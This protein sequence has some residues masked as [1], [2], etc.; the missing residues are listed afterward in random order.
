[1]EKK[2][3][4]V[5]NIKNATGNGN[6]HRPPNNTQR[7]ELAKL[8]ETMYV[9]KTDEAKDRNGDI[10]ERVKREISEKL[11]AAEL[12]R[13]IKMFEERICDFEKQK[14]EL[15]FLKYGGLD[16]GSKA[17]LLLDRRLQEENIEVSQLEEQKMTDITTVWTA[18]STEEIISVINGL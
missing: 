15:G 2:T 10:T 7:K 1:M 3:V 16:R 12:D 18:G 4:K 17:Q 11:G 8:I 5:T 13:Q 6:G 9:R 14:M